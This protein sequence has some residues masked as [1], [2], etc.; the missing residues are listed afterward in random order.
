[1]LTVHGRP[2]SPSDN[3]C[4]AGWNFASGG[5]NTGNTG[6]DF[7]SMIV[8]RLPFE[9][10]T[11]WDAS[12]NGNLAEQLI[13]PGLMGAYEGATITVLGKGVIF[14]TGTTLDDAFGVS[15]GGE[16]AAFPAGTLL[17]TGSTVDATRGC[18]PN[19]LGA[20]NRFPTNFYCNPSAID[21]LGIRNS[22]QGGGG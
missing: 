6:R 3:G 12:V 21:G 2:R 4:T 20:H 18:G 7:Q 22:S 15:A 1:G 19:T 9:G 8:D 14:P 10:T 16:E 13:E 11:G 17:L 5:L